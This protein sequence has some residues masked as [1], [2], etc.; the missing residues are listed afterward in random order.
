[1]G[2]LAQYRR[3]RRTPPSG[4]ARESVWHPGVATLPASGSA[5]KE[6]GMLGDQR[7][8]GSREDADAAFRSLYAEHGLAVDAHRVLA[9]HDALA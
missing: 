9:A 1:M 7:V 3:S 8:A 6:D 5:P 4:D 2:N